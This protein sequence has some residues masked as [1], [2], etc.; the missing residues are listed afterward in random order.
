MKMITRLLTLACFLTALSHVQATPV[1]VVI[2]NEAVSTQSTLGDL[3]LEDLADFS[4]AEI[5]AQIG[6]K[7][8]FGERIALGVTKRQAKRFAKKAARAAENQGETDGF[9]IA[10]LVLGIL[11]LVSGVGL[12]LSI[13]AI[14]FGSISKRRISEEPGIKGQG[15]AKAGFILGIIGCALAA[16]LLIF[17]FALGFLFI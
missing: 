17:L 15:M 5:E 1:S 13:L 8:T 14:V 12:L 16:L 10:S 4:R 11:G 9:A 7:L 3:T 6:R 2:P